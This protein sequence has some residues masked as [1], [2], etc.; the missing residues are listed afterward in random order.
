MSMVTICKGFYLNRIISIQP[1]N[2][3]FEQNISVV[4]FILAEDA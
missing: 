2:K 1:V 3:F 4:S